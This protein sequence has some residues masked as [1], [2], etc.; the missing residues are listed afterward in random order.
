MK[1]MIKCGLCVAALCAPIV[2]CS[3]VVIQADPALSG[4][5]TFLKKVQE[6]PKHVDAQGLEQF[7]KDILAAKEP[8]DADKDEIAVKYLV[9]IFNNKENLH[10]TGKEIFKFIALNKEK[11]KV[12]NKE[13]LEYLDN[14]MCPALFANWATIKQGEKTKPTTKPVQPV[15]KPVAPTSAPAQPSVPPIVP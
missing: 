11:I 7:K 3:A 9:G 4:V 2:H 5:K 8:S 13:Q 14:N 10:A 1:R 12:M 15:K 6:D